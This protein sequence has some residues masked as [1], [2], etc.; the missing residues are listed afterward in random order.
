MGDSSQRSSSSSAASSISAGAGSRTSSRRSLETG[1]QT[2]SPSDNSRNNNN[3]N[4]NNTPNQVARQFREYKPFEKVHK[5][6]Y[7][8]N[9]VT[10]D[11]NLIGRK[12]RHILPPKTW[13]YWDQ[14]EFLPQP[15]NDKLGKFSHWLGTIPLKF[16]TADSTVDWNKQQRMSKGTD[17]KYMKFNHK[18]PKRLAEMKKEA[19][20]NNNN[21][22]EIENYGQGF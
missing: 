12:F 19:S 10:V 9:G 15:K 16:R 14:Q 2:S 1:Y 7:L 8:G 18:M 3:N 5:E 11:L 13:I 6:D 21:N 20:Q 17:R 4:S 22:M